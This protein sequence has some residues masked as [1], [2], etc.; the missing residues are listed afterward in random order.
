MIEYY[1][2]NGMSS[3]LLIDT[4][5]QKASFNRPLSAHLRAFSQQNLCSPFI[6]ASV[7][8]HDIP[9]HTCTTCSRSTVCSSFL[10]SNFLRSWKRACQPVCTRIQPATVFALHVS[11]WIVRTTPTILQYAIRFVTYT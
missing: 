3:D 8:R 6:R 2:S 4:K 9:V 11:V 5:S 10:W 1:V 7:Q